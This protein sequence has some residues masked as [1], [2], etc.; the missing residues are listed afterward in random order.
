MICEFRFHWG[1]FKKQKLDA[2]GKK[3]DDEYEPAISEDE[4]TELKAA[5]A[6]PELDAIKYEDITTNDF[7]GN[8]V[9][10]INLILP[11]IQNI[12]IIKVIPISYQT[13]AATMASYHPVRS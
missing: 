13:A 8:H 2:E 11:I 5:I 7:W 4:W 6:N 12:E 10:D 3:I 1:V 9:A